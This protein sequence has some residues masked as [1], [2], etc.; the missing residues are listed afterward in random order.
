MSDFDMLNFVYFA[1]ART[2]FC[3]VLIWPL[4]NFTCVTSNSRC[5]S[6]RKKEPKTFDKFRRWNWTFRNFNCSSGFFLLLLFSKLFYSFV[7]QSICFIFTREHL[8]FSVSFIQIH[9]MCVFVPHLLSFAI[10][11][12]SFLICCDTLSMWHRISHA[13]C[14]QRMW[15]T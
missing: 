1:Y 15:E 7:R 10:V 14:W 4:T 11:S 6:K 2:H 3:I 12:L 8:Q 9:Q 5:E 13:M